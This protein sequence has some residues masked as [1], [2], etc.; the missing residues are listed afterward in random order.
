MGL[1]SAKLSMVLRIHRLEKPYYYFREI[2]A[3]RDCGKAQRVDT[4]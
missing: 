1:R 3:R 4:C 2:V